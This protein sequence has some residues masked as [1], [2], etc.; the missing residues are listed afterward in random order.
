M[1]AQIVNDRPEMR[2]AA[3]FL[4]RPQIVH[5]FSLCLGTCLAIGFLVNWVNRKHLV[6]EDAALGT[7][8]TSVFEPRHDL[9]V[10]M[11]NLEPLPRVCSHIAERRTDRSILWLGN[12]QLHAINQYAS[13]QHN[14]PAI[15]HDLLS[16]DDRFLLTISLP[17]ANLQ[18]HLAC[19]LAAAASGCKPSLIVL[20]AV[21]DDTREDG[22][23][24]EICDWWAHSRSSLEEYLAVPGVRQLESSL[25]SSG[26]SSKSIATSHFRTT[27]DR[28]EAELD[29]YLSHWS[30]IWRARGT[31]RGEV[32]L[33]LYKLR[34]S[35][36][37]INAQ[38]TRR[39]IASRYQKNMEAFDAILQISR[40]LDAKLLVYVAPLRGDVPPPYD[41]TEY[42]EFKSTLEAQCLAVQSARFLNLES[43]VPSGLWGQKE[44]TEIGGS[45]EIDFMHFQSEG[46][47][48]LAQRLASEIALSLQQ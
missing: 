43:L 30:A 10:H 21:F 13:G 4:S 38:T 24:T 23:R 11:A 6:L 42:A 29:R 2:P 14:A 25:A 35:A 37:G 39:R 19:I 44:G 22:V 18:E 34:N 12:S 20:P 3:G 7:G 8:T 1:H 36:F 32:F 17:N 47:W 46:H 9:P 28:S 41:P 5:G 31:L 40:M 48:L 15:L 16:R 26:E 45:L 27:M 33:N